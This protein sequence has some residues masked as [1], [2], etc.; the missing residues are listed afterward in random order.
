MHFL[1]EKK[2][3]NRMSIEGLLKSKPI[4]FSICQIALSYFRS[5]TSIFRIERDKELTV[6]YLVVFFLLVKRRM[7]VAILFAFPNSLLKLRCCVIFSSVFRIR[8][9]TKCTYICS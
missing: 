3:S 8:R 5:K 2:N 4:L 6:F 7:Y 1:F 9:N